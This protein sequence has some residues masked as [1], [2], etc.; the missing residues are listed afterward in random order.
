MTAKFSQCDK[1]KLT[2]RKFFKYLAHVLLVVSAKCARTDS[3][4]REIHS[5]FSVWRGEE[6]S[7][8]TRLWYVEQGKLPYIHGW[9]EGVFPNISETLAKIP[10]ESKQL[11][12][13]HRRLID[14]Y[15]DEYP[16]VSTNVHVYW[17]YCILDR[18]LHGCYDIRLR[19]VNRSCFRITLIHCHRY[20]INSVINT[21]M[22]LYRSVNKF[23]LFY[24][25]IKYRITE[26]SRRIKLEDFSRSIVRCVI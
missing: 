12:E 11:F 21:M 16:R 9:D 18:R 26:T 25:S 2:F 20:A 4:I 3:L 15:F 14:Y 7:N 24:F 6:I 8:S 23:Y 10:S 17:T 22:C 5:H 13:F 19:V 1:F